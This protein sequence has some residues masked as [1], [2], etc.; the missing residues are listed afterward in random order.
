MHYNI[1]FMKKYQL[2]LISNLDSLDNVD[3][4]VKEYCK[5]NNETLRILSKK[6]SKYYKFVL[7][8]R[9]HHN[10]RNN[11]TKTILY[12]NKTHLNV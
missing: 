12:S 11:K 1:V 5:K 4:F 3:N 7:Y 6:G 9:C 8:Y 10:T 2:M